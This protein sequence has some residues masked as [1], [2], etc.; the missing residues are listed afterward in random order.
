M[1]RSGLHG[2]SVGEAL[3]ASNQ[4][5]SVA[6]TFDDGSATD[7]LV[8]A[9]LLAQHNFNATFYAVS[10]WINRRGYLSATQLRELADAHFEIGC[11]SRS[12]AF[13]TDLERSSLRN[14][15]VTSKSELEQILGRRVEH[16]SCPG[17]RWSRRISHVAREAGY[18][19]VVTSRPGI[20][21]PQADPYRL[22][23]VAILRDVAPD[24]LLGISRGEKLLVRRGREFALRSAKT[25]LGNSTYERLR[26][27]FL[28][29]P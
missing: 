12:H 16:F 22:A 23:R 17:G 9:P 4:T 11:H 7:T 15:M 6:I 29:T 19:S 10:S 14:E 20:N 26:E 25:L 18:R 21:G 24:N 8:A 5:Q 27:V 1:A 3:S 13:L 28:K 2:T